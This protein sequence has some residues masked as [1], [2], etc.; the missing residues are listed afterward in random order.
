MTQGHHPTKEKSES[1]I[2][3][4]MIWP[5]CYFCGTSYVLFGKSGNSEHRPCHDEP[6]DIYG[7]VPVDRGGDITYFAQT[8]CG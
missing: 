2:I 6:N 5:I 7:I 8:S 4:K 3:R 1:P